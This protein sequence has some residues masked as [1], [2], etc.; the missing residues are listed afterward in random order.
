MLAY[1]EYLS[2]HSLF[3]CTKVFTCVFYFILLFIQV[4]FQ[5]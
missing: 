3:T 1:T 4:S 2:I 5:V